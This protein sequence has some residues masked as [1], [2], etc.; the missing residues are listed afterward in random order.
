M[1]FNAWLKDVNRLRISRNSRAK[2]KRL[3]F[4]ERLDD[5]DK[6]FSIDLSNQLI[7]KILLLTLLMLIITS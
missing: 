3:D 5:F 6:Y 7:R 1:R 2:G 4:A